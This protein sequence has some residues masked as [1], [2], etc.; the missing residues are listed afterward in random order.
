M[1]M[2]EWTLDVLDQVM[3]SGRWLSFGSAYVKCTG[4][5]VD[6]DQRHLRCIGRYRLTGENCDSDGCEHCCLSAG[7]AR[8]SEGSERALPQHLKTLQAVLPCPERLKHARVPLGFIVAVRRLLC[9][10][11]TAKEALKAYHLSTEDLQRL[12]I[13]KVGR[14]CAIQGRPAR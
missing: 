2:V 12:P 6:A 10:A 5:S 1:Q 7:A 11:V 4:A 13:C 3:M 8:L 14:E 9:T